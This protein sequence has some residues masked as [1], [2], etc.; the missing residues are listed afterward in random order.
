MTS[1]NFVQDPQEAFELR[2]IVPGSYYVLAMSTEG[3][4]Q[5]TAR[6]AID[7]SDADVEGVRLVI[8]PGIDLKGRIH[9]EVMPRWIRAFSISGCSHARR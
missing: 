1:Q 4:K 6:E 7:V 5:Y 3:D 9:V 2:G 8:G